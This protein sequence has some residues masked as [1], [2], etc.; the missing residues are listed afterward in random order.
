[1]IDPV[2]GNLVEV[3]SDMIRRIEQH[4]SVDAGGNPSAQPARRLNRLSPPLIRTPGEANERESAT[5]KSE[6]RRIG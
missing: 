2:T 3:P 6:S 1:M 4:R 5:A